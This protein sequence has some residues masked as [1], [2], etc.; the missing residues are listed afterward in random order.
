MHAPQGAAATVERDAALHEA[1]IETVLDEL[2]LTP[3]TGEKPPMVL[4]WLRLD[5]DNAR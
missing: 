4:P 2:A 5:D 3:G 1:W